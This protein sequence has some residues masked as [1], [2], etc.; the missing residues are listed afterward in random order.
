MILKLPVF[1][2]VIDDGVLISDLHDPYDSSEAAAAFYAVESLILAH[3]LAGVD[4]TTP[5][6][7]EG[8]EDAMDDVFKYIG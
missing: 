3:H 1:G 6:Y 2:I 7:L 4:V 5:A 8:I